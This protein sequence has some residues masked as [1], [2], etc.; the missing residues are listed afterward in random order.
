MS[1]QYFCKNKDRWKKVIKSTEI[2]G[3]D[4]L[5]VSSDDQKTLRL[6]FR[7]NLPGEP[8]GIPVNPPLTKDNIFIEGGVRVKHIE[9]ADPGG[10]V[11]FPVSSSGNVLTIVL[12]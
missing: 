8:G 9:I 4:Y 11:P 3:I 7:H 5:E 6:F 10:A 2:N 12:K 1:T